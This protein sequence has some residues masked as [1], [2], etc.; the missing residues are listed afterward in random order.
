MPQITALYAG[1]LALWSIALEVPIGRLRMA[2]NVSIHDGGNQ[3]L[4]VAIRR[5]ANFTEHVPLAL[6]LLALIELNGTSAGWLHALG[7]ILL[8][9]RVLH[10]F[11]LRA[12]VMR[13]PLRGIGAGG[14]LL[15]IAT[16]SVLAL[17]DFFKMPS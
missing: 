16:A 1:L 6:I 15:V 8:A 5:H 2:T 12:D 13:N 9:A 11:G 10:P 17:W 7:C 3:D 14:T 4:A